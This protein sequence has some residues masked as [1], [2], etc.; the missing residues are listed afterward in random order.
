VRARVWHASQDVRD[1][2][3]GAIKLTMNVCHD[4]ALRSWILSW[5][6][7]ARVVSPARLAQTIR[8]D[9]QAAGK[10]YTS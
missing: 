3:D 5:G 4:W 8:A 7:F 2:G 9:L 10:R 1:D 6:P